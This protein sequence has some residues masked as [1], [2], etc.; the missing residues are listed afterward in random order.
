MNTMTQKVIVKT[1]IGKSI[2][3]EHYFGEIKMAPANQTAKIM[4]GKTE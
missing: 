3:I 4:A 1:L 2:L